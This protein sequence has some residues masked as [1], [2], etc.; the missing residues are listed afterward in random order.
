MGS[1]IV[2]G[3]DRK[4]RVQTGSFAGDRGAKKAVNRG[5][6]VARNPQGRNLNRGRCRSRRKAPWTR[7]R[8]KFLKAWSSSET[9][10]ST[11]CLLVG[12]RKAT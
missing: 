10:G 4:E 8:N 5:E 2:P 3:E 11:A 6:P 9:K 12:E 1:K 7:K